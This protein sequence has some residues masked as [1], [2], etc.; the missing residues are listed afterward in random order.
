MSASGLSFAFAIAAGVL[1]VAANLAS[2]KSNGFARRGWGALSIVLV[3][4]AFALLAEAIK[5]MDLAVAYALLG[6]TG[7]FGTAICGRLFF[8]QRLKPVGWLGLSLIF[9]AV[10]VLHT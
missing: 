7:I 2:T 1:D 5:D 4:A 6:A 8:G 9:G 3:L 10:L